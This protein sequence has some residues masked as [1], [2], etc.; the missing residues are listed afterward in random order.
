MKNDLLVHKMQ[1]EFKMYKNLE[2]IDGLNGLLP[3]IVL[4]T[5]VSDSL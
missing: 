5:L 2:L 4:F 3:V 1:L